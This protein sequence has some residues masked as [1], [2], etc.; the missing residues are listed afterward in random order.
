MHRADNKDMKFKRSFAYAGGRLFLKVK[1]L[2]AVFFSTFA[3]CLTRDTF[4]GMIALI[5]HTIK[6]NAC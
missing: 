2:N 4:Q 1:M 5:L 6:H 3:D